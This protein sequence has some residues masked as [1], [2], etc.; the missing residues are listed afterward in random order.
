MHK[1]ITIPNKICP[2]CGGTK[3]VTWE[4][5]NSVGKIYT[6]YQCHQLKIEKRREW[7]RNKI[8]KEPD[9]F[10]KEQ[11]KY[12]TEER[13]IIYL[14]YAQFLQLSGER[15]KYFRQYRKENKDRLSAKSMRWQK[16]NPEK[17]KEIRRRCNSK[18]MTNLS[19]RYIKQLLIRQDHKKGVHISFSEI[20]Q[21]LITIKTKMLCLK[22]K[23]KLQKTSVM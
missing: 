15:D 3:W 5:K 1:I 18:I 19:P 22:R 2:H 8:A 17:S 7:V 9:Y 16:N 21:E 20:P 11:L 4:Q 23:L 12:M 14:I 10:K 13:R 6:I